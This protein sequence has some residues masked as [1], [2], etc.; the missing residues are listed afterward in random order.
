M[1]RLLNTFIIFSIGFTAIY[2]YKPIIFF[3]YNGN[4]RPFKFNG[5]R[6]NSVLTLHTFTIFLAFLSHIL[7]S[8]LK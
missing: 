6:I 8:R 5:R 1:S 7:A 2:M 3:D 4:V